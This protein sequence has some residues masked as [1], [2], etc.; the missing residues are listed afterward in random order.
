[1]LTA[2]LVCPAMSYAQGYGVYE[3]GACTM[4]RGGTAVATP[5]ADGSGIYFN[6]AGIAGRAFSGSIGGALIAPNATFIND[7]TGLESKFLSKIYPVPTLY[8]SGPIA[9]RFA[10][11]LGVFVPYGLTTEWDENTFEGRFL[12]YHTSLRAIYIQPTVAAQF[13]KLKLGAG[14]DLTNLHIDLQR[15]AD[16]SQVVLPAGSPVPPGTTFGA[17]GIPYGTD[18]ADTKIKGGAWGVG[19]NLGA[20]YEVD[21]R[22]ILGVRYTARQKITADGA[23]AEFAQVPTGLVLTAGNPFGL[24]AGT[25]VDALV[26]GQFQSGGLLVPQ[27]VSA[28]IRLPEQLVLGVTIKPIT[29][30]AVSF[31]A[32]R[33]WWN[34]FE[35][36][37]IDFSQSDALDQTLELGA[38]NVWTWRFG[39]EYIFS[40]SSSTVGRAGLI[41]HKAALPDSSVTPLLPEA[42][43]T[44]FSLGFGTRIKHGLYLDAAYM[45]VNQA[46]RRG[47]TVPLTLAE[48]NGVYD[49][50]AHLFGVTL[51]VDF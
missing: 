45:Y 34:V 9:D 4:G 19:Y 7:N 42:S 44:D 15:K 46:D 27:D 39:G 35:S 26:A 50:H 25:P 40:E 32:Q 13:G 47:R 18:F 23:T 17:L 28:S 49:E 43:R 24:P 2:A 14:L 38:S 51:T 5:C 29:D 8:I 20:T 31:D 11:G 37:P 10:V 12:G 22:F 1:M 30:L 3:Q 16:L 36:V 6:P 48:T 33:T 21:P 41:F